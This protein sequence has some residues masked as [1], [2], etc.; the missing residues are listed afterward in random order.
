[1]SKPNKSVADKQAYEAAMQKCVEEKLI[2]SFDE[3]NVKS[4]NNMLGDRLQIMILES[5][6]A[7]SE[8]SKNNAYPADKYILY[9]DKVTKKPKNKPVSKDTVEEVDSIDEETKEAPKKTKKSTGKRNVTQ[10]N[11]NAKTVL[12]Y[13]V[14]S[15]IGEV[16]STIDVEAKSLKNIDDFANAILKSDR[17]QENKSNIVP[18]VVSTVMAYRSISID[19]DDDQL[20]TKLKE[21]LNKTFK[22]QKI[23]R[24]LNYAAEMIMY[25][26]KGLAA[27]IAQLLWIKPSATNYKVLELAI[28]VM[29]L[30]GEAWLNEN[31]HSHVKMNLDALLEATRE[32]DNAFNPAAPKK[33]PVK[34][35]PKANKDNAEEPEEEAKAEASAKKPIKRVAVKAS[36]PKKA[37]ETKKPA[38]KKPVKA[39]DSDEESE[40]NNSDDDIP[41]PSDDE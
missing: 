32:V 39:K 3:L 18:I 27:N 12:F 8:K 26:F 31:K 40:D 17:H 16:Q 29:S 38:T 1:M 4:I 14:N 33:A 5:I 30:A 22:E 28:R 34:K 7:I 25:F 24:K 20:S 41:D 10:I 19:S 37:A 11:K 36:E 35:A 13:W 23:E 9:D 6:K 2:Y 15:F 21:K